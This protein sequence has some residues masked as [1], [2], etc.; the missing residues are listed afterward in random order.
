MS[1][2][3]PTEVLVCQHVNAGGPYDRLMMNATDVLVDG[4]MCEEC[5]QALEQMVEVMPEYERLNL[6][7]EYWSK[8]RFNVPIQNICRA[9]ARSLGI[10]DKTPN[11]EHVWSRPVQ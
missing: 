3:R 9:C 2:N 5:A 6:M 7:E 11:G 10:P 1:C 4:A 8:V